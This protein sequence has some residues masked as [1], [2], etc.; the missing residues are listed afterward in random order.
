MRPATYGVRTMAEW[1]KLRYPLVAILR[2]VRPGEVE[3]IAEALVGE[4]IEAIEVP[5][6]SPDPLKSIERLAARLGD[7]ALIGGGTMLSVA[8]VEN[9]FAAGGR[10]MVSPNVVPDVI[11][12]ANEMGMVTMPGVMTPTEAFAALGAGA[13]AL[14][15]FPAGVLGPSGISA[16][17]AVLPKD[18]II[19]AVGGVGA[20]NMADFIKAGVTAFGLGTGL[21]RPGDTAQTVAARAK[22]VCAAYREVEKTAR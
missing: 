3:E 19:G 18:T 6:N 11:R 13:T 21:Y 1:P 8:D 20:E 5:L 2:E 15:F 16:V 17:K 9:V 7:R 4:G 10:L 12:R 14:K 22:D